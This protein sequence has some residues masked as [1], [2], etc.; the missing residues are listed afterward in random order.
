MISLSTH[1]DFHGRSFTTRKYRNG[2]AISLSIK[3][4]SII[5][6]RH[7]NNIQE[8]SNTC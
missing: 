7:T 3:L 4:L 5:I 8:Q 6:V 2:A 1:T